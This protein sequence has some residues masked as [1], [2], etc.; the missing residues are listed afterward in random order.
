[1]SNMGVSYKTNIQ[2]L[3]PKLFKEEEEYRDNK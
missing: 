3:S 1:M 2:I